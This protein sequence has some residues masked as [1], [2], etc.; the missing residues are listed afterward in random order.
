MA[1]YYAIDPIMDHQDPSDFTWAPADNDVRAKAYAL[2]LRRRKALRHSLVKS[3][4]PKRLVD[5]RL[6][7][8]F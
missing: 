8:R 7:A 5:S 2:R 3:H 6:L 1:Q 4:L